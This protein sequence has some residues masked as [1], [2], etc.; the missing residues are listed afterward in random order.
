MSNPVETY[1]CALNSEFTKGDATEHTHRPALKRLIEALSPKVIA[2]NE[3]KAIQRENKPDY[4]VRRDASIVGFVEAKDI[5][6]NLNEAAKT[7]QLKRYLDALP[8]LILTNYVDFVWFVSG[9][10]RLEFSLGVLSGKTIFLNE[11][12]EKDWINFITSFLNE[13]TPTVS[14]PL[15]LARSLAGQTRLLRELVAELVKNGDDD[16]AQQELAF[17]TL[18]VPNLG[19]GEFGDMYA[20]TAA[21]GLFTARV[22]NHTSLFGAPIE[23]LPESL[24]QEAFSLEQA[25]YLIPKANP[26]LRQFFQH[27]ASPNLNAQLRWLIEQIAD[28]LRYANIE[29]VLHRHGKK[30]GFEDPIFHFYETF[31]AE[32]DQKLREAR[33]VYFTPEPVVD[34]MVRSVDALLQEKFK[35]VEGLADRN[36]IILDPATGTA[37]FLRKIIDTIYSRV[38]QDG[39]KGSWPQYVRERLLNRI[40]GFELMMAPY[41]I[42][43][44]KLSLQLQE[45][46]FQFQKGERLHVYLTNTLDQLRNKSAALLGAWIAE[47]NEGAE[48]V[49]NERNVEVVIGNPPYLG[50]SRNKSKWIL[51]LLKSYKTEPEGGPLKEKNSKWLNDDYV[52]FFRFA[53]DRI[54]RSGQGIVALITP[55][56]WLDNPTFRGM[57]AQLMRD[58]DQIFVLDLHGNLKKKET[59]P[60]AFVDQGIDKNV[61]D[62]EQGVAITFL[63]KLAA[64]EPEFNLTSDEFSSVAMK[65]KGGLPSLKAEIFHADLWG[66]REF[67][68]SWLSEHDVGTVS[69]TTVAPAM[70]QLHITPRDETNTSEY[71]AGWSVKDIM[72]INGTG[73]VTKCDQLNISFTP[74]E[75]IQRMKWFVSHSEADVRKAVRLPK[76]TVR[77]WKFNAAVQDVMDSKI[78]PALVRSVLYRP[79]DT[80]FVYYT[81]RSRGVIGWPV[82]KLMKHF[83]V[84][85][86]N[87]GL[88]TSR[89]TKGEDFAHVQIT[90]QATEVICM[91]GTTSNNGFLFPLW[92]LPDAS[93]PGLLESTQRVPNF[94]SSFLIMLATNLGIDK[95][96]KF[97]LPEG[98]QAEDILAYI[99]AVLHAPSY[100]SRYRE[101]LKSD[102]PRI[103]FCLLSNKPGGLAEIWPTVVALGR[104]LIDMHLLR[105]SKSPTQVTFPMHGSGKV[106][107]IRFDNSKLGEK[108]K[109]WINEDQYFDHV[110]LGAWNFKVGGYQVC[111]KWLKDR[112]GRTLTLDEV[113]HY[114][115]V[116]EA[117]RSTLL[118]MQNIDISVTGI[119][120]PSAEVIEVCAQ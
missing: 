83:P 64:T 73:I 65:L 21:Y 28:S 101:Y 3:P 79:F 57:R 104:Q 115:N 44:L 76:V 20:Q 5:G 71:E 67:K 105:N 93:T 24:K 102:F 47:E 62:I 112:V 42:A 66:G 95:N 51:N 100:R 18:L 75:M 86:G 1:V 30:V 56:G 109:V 43:H 82:T 39:K 88:L 59:T 80:R 119:L 72:P 58:F 89:M 55:H 99:Y 38:C 63:V 49:K 29:K 34:F 77:D 11:G 110:D 61:F 8:N 70:P 41:T 113:E 45:Q 50:E 36:T 106:E 96:D 85:S 114:I 94:S 6:A 31:L 91:S 13:V 68:Y 15:Q 22:F 120:W 12:A 14:T 26:F 117:L 53:H 23:V 35:R 27:I 19:S 103:P 116:V 92:L 16:L 90:D 97:G 98:V 40:Y 46:G 118:I 54:S 74:A 87:I 52:K 2:T 37:T 25:A 84:G 4:I 32:Y 33:G 7:P 9:V 111:N 48:K 107:K 10:K 108:G 81:G 60:T 78:N 17:K 69:W